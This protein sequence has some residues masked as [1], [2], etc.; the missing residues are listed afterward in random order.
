[1]TDSHWFFP[2]QL[3]L[4]LVEKEDCVRSP[5]EETDLSAFL[6]A[7]D[8][9]KAVAAADALF[10]A[11]ALDMLFK[12]VVE[13]ECLEKDENADGGLKDFY[14]EFVF[15]L[16]SGLWEALYDRT[17]DMDS[18]AAVLDGILDPDSLARLL[19][20]AWDRRDIDESALVYA[21]AY[22]NH[23]FEGRS[24]ALDNAPADL[25]KALL[26]YAWPRGKPNGIDQWLKEELDSA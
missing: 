13:S 23:V 20:N 6:L 2:E 5:T 8:W 18:R 3:A 14:Q 21:S 4:S 12:A 10:R 1:M 24:Q 19:R 7:C 9:P 17:T 26:A 15:P 11:G 25:L 16:P 22:R